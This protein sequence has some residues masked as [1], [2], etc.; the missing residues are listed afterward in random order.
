MQP[1]ERK[2]ININRKQILF[3]W[4]EHVPYKH[5]PEL[6]PSYAEVA[7]VKTAMSLYWDEK[8]Y[9]LADIFKIKKKLCAYQKMFYQARLVLHF[10]VDVGLG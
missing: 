1:A 10:I 4:Q 5:Y 8:K 3:R 2:T 6:E 7:K 9:Y